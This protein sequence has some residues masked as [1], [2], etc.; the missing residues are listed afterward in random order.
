MEAVHAH[1]RV[2]ENE[3]ACRQS[4]FLKLSHEDDPMRLI[5][6]M[7]LLVNDLPILLWKVVSEGGFRWRTESRKPSRSIKVKGAESLTS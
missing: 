7:E 4:V 3:E 5:Y 1:H 2:S 6:E